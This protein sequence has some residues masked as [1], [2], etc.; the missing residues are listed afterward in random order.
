MCSAAA[1]VSRA[2]NAA[3]TPE[4]MPP[5]NNTTDRGFSPATAQHPSANEICLSCDGGSGRNSCTMIHKLSQNSTGLVGL[6]VAV[7]TQQS[8]FSHRTMVVA[9]AE[10]SGGSNHQCKPKLKIDPRAPRIKR[11]SACVAEC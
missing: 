11:M 10:S 4:S 9:Q 8:A 2:A 6:V 5:L 7:S 3:Q 1:S